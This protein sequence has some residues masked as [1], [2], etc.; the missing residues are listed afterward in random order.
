MEP[1]ISHRDVT[2]IMVLLG[3]IRTDVRAIRLLLEEDNGEAEEEAP[4]ADS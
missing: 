4:E 1:L 3:D 2:T